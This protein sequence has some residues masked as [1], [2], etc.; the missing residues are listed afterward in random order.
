MSSAVK[1]IWNRVTTALIAIVVL[2]ALLI[3][4]AR[5][6]GLE[7]FTVLSGSMEPEYPVGS[8]IYVQKV[9]YR[10]LKSG[11]VITFMLDEKTVATHRIV[12]V[13]PDEND[14]SVLRFRTKGDANNIEDGTPIHYKNV[15]GSPVFMIPLL[16]YVAN[17][18]QNPPG[19]Y[20]TISAAAVLLILVF[21]PDLLGGK[22]EKQPQ[23]EQ[24]E[25]DEPLDPQQG[26]Q[27][28]PL[29]PQQG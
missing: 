6:F 21:L 15:L 24:G 22:E 25:Q 17:Y 4:G 5:I 18:I 28:E 10:E 11:D 29:D 19:F 14:P 16:G 8:L 20:I 26:E 27:D 7:V 12:E 23:D 9:D 1:K 13:L 3:V 2:L